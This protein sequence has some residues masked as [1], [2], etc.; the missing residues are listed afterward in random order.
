MN[1]NY[2]QD[3]YQF[4]TTDPFA[5]GGQKYDADIF[6]MNVDEVNN[7]K[8]KK[9][10]VDLHNINTNNKEQLNT[11]FSN[12]SQNKSKSERFEDLIK[13]ITENNKQQET[14]K[15]PTIKHANKKY[16]KI[17]AY[18]GIAAY[19]IVRLIGLFI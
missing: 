17:I 10:N 4:R 3:S 6:N 13:K 9:I 12:N 1:N 15:R 2:Q 18:I 11:I 14:N 8:N 5:K 7:Y 16:T 19:F